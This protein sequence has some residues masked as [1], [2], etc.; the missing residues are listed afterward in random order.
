METEDPRKSV[1]D[2][3]DGGAPANDQETSEAHENASNTPADELPAKD[4][5]DAADNPGAPDEPN[6]ADEPNVAY[7]TPVSDKPDAF[8]HSG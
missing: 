3:S 8:I 2:P 6:K 7:E 1:A 4:T 5:S